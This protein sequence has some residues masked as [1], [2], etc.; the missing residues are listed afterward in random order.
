M[1]SPGGVIVREQ[2]VNVAEFAVA[3]E[4]GTIATMGL[5]SC[6]AIVL[7]DADARIGALAHVLLPHESLS[8]DRGHPAKF[9]TTAVPLLLREL[10]RAGSGGPWVAKLVGGASMF[11]ALLAG[12]GINMGERNLAAVRQ[13][14][15]AA[16]I[17]VV[18]EDVGGDYGRSAYLDVA[19]GVVRV[20]SIR[21]GE[22]AL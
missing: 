16:R 2:L 5:G 10:G 1:A 22:H 8:R 13:A 4:T 3:C 6:V 11:G 21:H 15:A 18:A 19:T 7:H 14:L 17:P 9:A 20:V 12:G